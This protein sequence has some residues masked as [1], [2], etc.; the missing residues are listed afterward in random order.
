M[1][2]VKY[3]GIAIATISN[4]DQPSKI[5]TYELGLIRPLKYKTVIV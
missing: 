2:K 1:L 5:E 3:S 4:F